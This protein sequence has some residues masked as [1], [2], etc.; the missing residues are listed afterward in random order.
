MVVGAIASARLPQNPQGLSDFV[1]PWLTPFCMSVGPFT[2]TM[3]AYLSATYAAYEARDS[4]LAEDFRLRAIGAALATGILA[5]AAPIDQWR[6]CYLAWTDSS[7]MDLA[8][9]LDHRDPC[10]DDT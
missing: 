1:M 5:G 4:E 6:I 8:A 7:S 3:F 2:V 9:V 10:R